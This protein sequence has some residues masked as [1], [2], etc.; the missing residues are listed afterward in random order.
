MRRSFYA[1]GAQGRGHDDDLFARD[2]E[3]GIGREQSAGSIGLTVEGENSPKK[4][5]RAL[6]P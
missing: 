1:A 6:N 2:A 3:A 5:F 4:K